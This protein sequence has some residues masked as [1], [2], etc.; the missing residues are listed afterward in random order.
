MC[1]KIETRFFDRKCSL[2]SFAAFEEVMQELLDDR[3]IRIER[4]YPV[5]SCYSSDS[6]CCYDEDEILDIISHHLNKNFIRAIP[7]Y[8]TE[9]I[10]FIEG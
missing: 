8:D 7:I 10:Y 4:D 1:Q 6:D 2:I 3:T 9:Y 5:L